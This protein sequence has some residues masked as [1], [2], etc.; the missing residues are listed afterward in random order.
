MNF[1]VIGGAGFI[2]AYVTRTL[3]A[4]GHKVVVYDMSLAENTLGKVLSAEE[5]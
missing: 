1:L 4:Q 5:L 2:G 3:L